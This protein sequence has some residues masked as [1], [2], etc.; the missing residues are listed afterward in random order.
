MVKEIVRKGIAIGIIVF[1]VSV[2]VPIQLESIIIASTPKEHST[3]DDRFD[4][5]I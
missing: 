2:T 5:L 1:L 4:N 3:A